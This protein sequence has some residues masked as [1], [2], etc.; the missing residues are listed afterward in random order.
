MSLAFEQGEIILI[1]KPY[2]WT[3][4]D[5]VNYI[6]GQ[7]K[8]HLGITK[9]K[10][11]HAGTLDPLATGLLILC[12]GA[13]TR[14]IEEFQGMEKEYSGEL[15]LGA[16]TP[17]FDLE[18]EIDHTFPI[19]HIH[20]DQIYTTAATFVG[21]TKQ[22]PPVFSA[23][24]IQGKRAY[25][26]ARKDMK[27]AL[28]PVSI[29]IYDFEIT[30]IDLPRLFFRITCSK[31]TYIR[32]IARDFGIALT[33]GAYLGSL[34]RTRIGPYNLQEAYKPEELRNLILQR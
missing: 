28:E 4:F 24:K 19:N 13:F 18:T 14:R 23:K 17:S 25:L 29:Q 21:T 7:I 31:G 1:N 9:I 12:T 10:I 26:Y 27:V 16:T 8:V 11:G 15:I 34:T 6:R 2:G 22:T 30:R 33:T 20:T 3:S 5:V 32:A